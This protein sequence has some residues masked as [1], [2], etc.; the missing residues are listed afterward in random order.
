MRFGN[1]RIEFLGGRAGCL[2]MLVISVVASV[3]L[4]VLLNALL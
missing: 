4:T 2:T 1:T 3:L